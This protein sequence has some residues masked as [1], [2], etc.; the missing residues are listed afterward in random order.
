MKIA[1]LLSLILVAAVTGHG[2]LSAA[3]FGNED[4][5]AQEAAASL[6]VEDA[7]LTARLVELKARM[8]ALEDMAT[9]TL[10]T[11]L[12]EYKIR[13]TA[14]LNTL[15]FNIASDESAYANAIREYSSMINDEARYNEYGKLS[16]EFR[17]VSAR[18]QEVR[19]NLGYMYQ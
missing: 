1:N 4:T 12:R 15:G 10:Q 7:Q 9:P 6:N 18:S 8:T 13:M 3:Y 16:E 2:S 19:D 17:A 5:P 14:T 11:M